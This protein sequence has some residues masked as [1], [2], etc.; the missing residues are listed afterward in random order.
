ML[1]ISMKKKVYVI[2]VIK[3]SWTID[4]LSTCGTTH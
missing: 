3:F 1:L 4:P 2:Y